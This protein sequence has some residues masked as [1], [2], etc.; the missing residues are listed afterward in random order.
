MADKRQGAITLPIYPWR[1]SLKTAGRKSSLPEDSLWRAKNF[2][3]KLDGLLAKR[4]GL[5]KWGQTLKTFDASATGSTTTAFSDFINGTGGF[6]ATDNSSGKID[7]PTV[8]EGYMQANVTK[9]TSNEN[10]TLDYG[11]TGAGNEWSLRFL[12]KGINLPT[13]TADDTDPNT[14]SF[15]G[16]GAAGTGKQFAIWS[17]G[18][19]YKQALDDTYVLVTDTEY[20]GAGGWNTIEVRVDD[21]GGNTLVYFNETLVDTIS[22]ALIKDVALSGAYYGFRWEVEGTTD[23]GVQYTTRITT[24][25]Y[26]NTVTDPFKVVEVTTLH[27]YQYT[28]NAGSPKKSLLLAAGVYIYHDNGL[29]GAWRPL[30]AKKF[31]NIFFT[32]YRE[33]VVWF[34]HDSNFGSNVWR[35]D[36]QGKDPELLDDAPPMHAGGEHQQRLWGFGPKHPLRLFYSGDRQENVWFSPDEDNIEDEF[37]VLVSAGYLSIPSQTKGDKIT[38]FRGG[39]FGIAV[40]CTRHGAYRVLGSGINSYKIERIGSADAGGAENPWCITDMGNDLI[41]LSRKGLHSIAATDQFGDLT[42]ALISKDIQDLWG[43]DT[44]SVETI[45]REFLDRARLRYNPQQGLLY[46]CVPLTG[47]TEAKKVFVYNSGTQ[48]WMGPWTIDSRAIEN[49]E[50]STP[51]IEVMMHGGANGQVGYTDQSWKTD[52]G[53]DGYEAVLESAFIDGKSLDPRLSGF[54]KSWRRLR[55]YVLPRGDWEITVGW[56]SDDEERRTESVS[57]NVRNVHVLTEDFKLTVNPDGKLRSLE[58]IV[59]VEIRLDSRGKSLTF[60]IT[61]PANKGEDLIIQGVEIDFLADGYE[62]E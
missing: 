42:G 13:Y 51:E 17:G 46:C 60:D 32:N 33:S 4:P 48:Q 57:Q 18:L 53:T 2:T 30:K 8:F 22:S 21:D 37:S 39:Y 35:W 5:K 7:A 28:S 3:T 47:D 20:A 11:G 41:T 52:F 43:E 29:Q 31:T 9:G 62:E 34:D 12:F 16:I 27:D 38:A 36:G 56:Y 40:V 54:E 26:N 61:S 45:S 50:I 55:V 23:A 1:G 25:M 44:A 59:A 58:Q 10:Y 24:P 49:V 15:T 14:F 6:S 19:Y